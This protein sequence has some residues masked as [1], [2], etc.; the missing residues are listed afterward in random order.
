MNQVCEGLHV[1]YI[2]GPNISTRCLCTKLQ[3][4]RLKLRNRQVYHIQL[5]GEIHK[6]IEDRQQ[7]AGLLQQ[8][9]RSELIIVSYVRNFARNGT[10][11]KASEISCAKMLGIYKSEIIIHM[12]K[13]KKDLEVS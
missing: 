1:K 7:Q 11:W 6:Q 5:F 3:H 2:Q 8:A 13:R 9:F 4:D 10:R 12:D